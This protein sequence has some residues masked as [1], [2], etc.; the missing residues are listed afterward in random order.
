MVRYG[1]TEMT[2]HRFTLIVKG[3]DLQADRLVDAPNEACCDD[4]LVGI[5]DGIQC[6]DFDR[7]ASSPERAILSAVVDV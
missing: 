1:D 6:L 2:T 7:E 5:A 4:A 3:P